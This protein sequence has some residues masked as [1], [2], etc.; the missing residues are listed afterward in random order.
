[1]QNTD[2]KL[3]RSTK[4]VLAIL[5]LLSMA[6]RAQEV[7]ARQIVVS[8]PDRKLALIV[9]GE[10]VKVYDVAVG[11]DSSPSPTGSFTI[12][13]RL[14]DPTYYHKGTVIGPGATNPLGNRWI[15]L[16]QKGYGIHGTNEPKSIGKAA[17][18]G[19]IRM[20]RKDLV[21]FFAR[22]KVGDAVEIH[23]DRD[24]QIAKMFGN[25]QSVI[26]AS[27][28]VPASTTGQ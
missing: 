2:N 25:P 5:V 12:V 9:N 11:R 23:G 22:V 3:K 15:G 26:T 16:D 4:W 8:V 7:V 19:C 6:A 13:N 10:V 20:G 1:M 28:G 18:H 14:T 21:D 24:E 17:S 27:A